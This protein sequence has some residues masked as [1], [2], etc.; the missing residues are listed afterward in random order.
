MRAKLERSVTLPR[1]CG[2]FMW[3]SGQGAKAVFA[4]AW[5]Q[6]VLLPAHPKSA[7]IARAFVTAQLDLRGLTDEVDAIQLVTSELVTNAIRHA[8]TPFTVTV[9][10]DLS[11]VRLMVRDDD[12]MMDSAEPDFL[13]S[14]G[15]RGLRIAEAFSD[16][17]GV[18][19]A[20]DGKTVW[21]QFDTTT[22]PIPA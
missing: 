5:V 20:P 1:P 17:W 6:H 21:A 15:G 14:L 9:Q 16:A 22:T 4:E 8:R 11:G 10:G 3:S 18:D 7:G 19:H 13:M 12:P 2:C